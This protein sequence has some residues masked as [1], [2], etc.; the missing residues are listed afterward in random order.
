MHVEARIV[1]RIGVDPATELM[2]ALRD[3]KVHL[4]I[5]AAGQGIVAQPSR[6]TKYGRMSNRQDTQLGLFR[7]GAKPSR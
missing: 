1:R 2:P 5:A 4:D 7:H 3:D 6:V